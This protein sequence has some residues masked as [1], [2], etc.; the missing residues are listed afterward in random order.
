MR[1]LCSSR[2]L[3]RVVT[4]P[5]LTNEKSL[6]AYN[7]ERNNLAYEYDTRPPPR[8]SRRIYP[9]RANHTDDERY[10]N[11]GQND[12]YERTSAPCR[13]PAYAGVGVPAAR[14]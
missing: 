3:S 12:D 5:L 6:R 10:S 7:A 8:L 14:R 4:W 13:T 1:Y 11:D 2:R 9:P